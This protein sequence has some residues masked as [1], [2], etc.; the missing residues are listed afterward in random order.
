MCVPM[1]RAQERASSFHRDSAGHNGHQAGPRG[2][3]RP[4]VGL[5]VGIH[6]QHATAWLRKVREHHESPGLRRVGRGSR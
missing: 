1:H 4:D 6:G 5:Q 3:G 2:Q